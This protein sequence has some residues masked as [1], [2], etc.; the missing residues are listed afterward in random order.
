MSEREMG[1]FVLMELIRPPVVKNVLLTP[2][3]LHKG[4]VVSELGVFGFCLWRAKKRAPTVAQLGDSQAVREDEQGGVEFVFNE[5]G[6]W[7]FKTKSAKVDEMSVVKGY[8]CFDS[9]MLCE[10]LYDPVEH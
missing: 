3:G 5:Q 8:G 1:A 7:S 6:G 10:T 9:P 2:R 4:P